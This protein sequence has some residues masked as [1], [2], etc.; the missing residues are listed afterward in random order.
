METT[1]T[2]PDQPTPI[3][4]REDG[5]PC[6]AL[7]GK[8]PSTLE[9]ERRCT[10]E[11]G[12]AELDPYVYNEDLRAHDGE[13]VGTWIVVRWVCR[14]HVHGNVNDSREEGI[15]IGRLTHGG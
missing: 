9:E 5:R 14:G 4:V 1:R 8:T 13:I 15:R 11:G 2:R 6:C 7:C 3:H 12:G 10:E